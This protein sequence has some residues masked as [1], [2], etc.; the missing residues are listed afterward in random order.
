M[1]V[2]GDWAGV[3]GVAESAFSGEGQVMEI[4]WVRIE[5]RDLKWDEQSNNTHNTNPKL[6]AITMMSY[7]SQCTGCPSLVPRFRSG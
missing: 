6:N 2:G 3:H 1:A 5:Q 7:K 4:D